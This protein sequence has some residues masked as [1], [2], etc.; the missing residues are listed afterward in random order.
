MLSRARY[1][2]HQ[3]KENI[4]PAAL[5]LDEYRRGLKLMKNALMIPTPDYIKDDRMRFV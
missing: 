1:Y 3:F 2:I 4:Q 5:A